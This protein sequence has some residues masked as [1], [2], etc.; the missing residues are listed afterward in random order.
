MPT[1]FPPTAEILRYLWGAW[2][3][4]RRD[5]QGMEVFG[6]TVDDFWQSFWA[7][8]LVAP[9]YISVSLVRYAF[10]T[11]DGSFVRFIGAEAATYA[12]LWLAFPFIMLFVARGID[13][14]A[15]YIR[16]IVAYNWASVLQSIFYTAVV[17]IGMSGLLPPGTANF[18]GFL[19]LIAILVYTWF[20]TRTAL[21]I[22]GLMAGGLVAIDLTL[23]LVIQ[24]IGEGLKG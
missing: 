10:E 20:I 5:E 14:E 6:D 23:G 9:L 2:R 8:A 7:A 15:R 22:P 24:S 16:F 19:A 21:D 12:N 4:V 11:G 3:L 1:P 18:M 13:R 17:Y